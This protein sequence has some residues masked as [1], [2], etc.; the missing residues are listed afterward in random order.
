VEKGCVFCHRFAVF[1]VPQGAQRFRRGRK[2]FASFAQSHCRLRIKHAR[3]AAGALRN[4]REAL[5][6][7]AKPLRPLRYKNKVDYDKLKED[8]RVQ[9]C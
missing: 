7:F 3:P 1:F 5:A 4:G 9:T 2:G 8:E 6:P